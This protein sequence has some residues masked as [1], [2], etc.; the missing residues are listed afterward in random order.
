MH[1]LLKRE[2]LDLKITPYQVRARG[3]SV[4]GGCDCSCRLVLCVPMQDAMSAAEHQLP[5]AALHVRRC[6]RPPAPTASSSLC[7]RRYVWLPLGCLA[8]AGQLLRGAAHS[9]LDAK[10][11]RT[12][13]S[14]TQ[15]V[16]CR[17]LHLLHPPALPLQPLAR[18]LAENRSIHRFLAMHHP[19]PSGEQRGGQVWM[20][21]M[22]HR[23]TPHA[24]GF[25]A[26]TPSAECVAD[27]PHTKLTSLCRAVW[28]QQRGAVHVCE[29][30][31]RVS[32]PSAGMVQRFTP[33][34]ELLVTFQEQPYCTAVAPS[35]HALLAAP[36]P[37][38]AG[39]A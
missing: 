13:S 38:R 16:G 7:H 31:R 3:A 20:G 6:W 5:A 32:F 36:P 12:L 27:D 34:V 19:D 29:E 4:S 35:T 14:S 33:T 11:L 2:H 21:W 28:A 1:R 30:L 10:A 18:V 9:A 39:T 37:F 24:R 23:W 25:G 8:A 22:E 17:V 15:L 26:S